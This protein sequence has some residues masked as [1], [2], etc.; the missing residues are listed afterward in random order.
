MR[1][2]TTFFFPFRVVANDLANATV[3]QQMTEQ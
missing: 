2:L 3:K 1:Q